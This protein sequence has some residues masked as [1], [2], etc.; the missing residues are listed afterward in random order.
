MITFDVSSPWT[1]KKMTQVC[2]QLLCPHLEAVVIGKNNMTFLRILQTFL[3]D[4]TIYF[5]ATAW[6]ENSFIIFFNSSFTFCL[7]LKRLHGNLQTK[8][9]N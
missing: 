5:V 6:D 4:L 9:T 3:L 1:S 7:F 8:G 2:D